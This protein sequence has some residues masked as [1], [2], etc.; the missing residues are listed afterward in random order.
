MVLEELEKKKEEIINSHMQGMIQINEK[1]V[2]LIDKGLRERATGI[3]TNV[4]VLDQIKAIFHISTD[5]GLRMNS[6]QRFELARLYFDLQK[7]NIDAIMADR[8]QGYRS[9][10]DDV[11][12]QIKL[13]NE[14]LKQIKEELMKVDSPDRKT[15]LEEQEKDL[16]RGGF[17]DL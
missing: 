10:L 1:L 11:D 6:E 14:Q 7:T 2:T 17:K 13:A 9:L 8:R 15:S 16:K 12:D 5:K 4:N 3:E